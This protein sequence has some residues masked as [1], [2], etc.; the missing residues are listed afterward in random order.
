VESISPSRATS[1]D[2]SKE[3]MRASTLPMLR[4]NTNRIVAPRRITRISK[5]KLLHSKILRIMEPRMRR[6]RSQKL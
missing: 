1:I 6:A 2:I 4:H 5:R 3:S